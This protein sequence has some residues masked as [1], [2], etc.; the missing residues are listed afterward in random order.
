[1]IFILKSTDCDETQVFT[2]CASLCEP[3]CKNF[4]GNMCIPLRD[5]CVVNVCKCREGHARIKGNDLC[6]PITS[7]ECGGLYD[8][9]KGLQAGIEEEVIF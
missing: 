8:P 7:K 9:V 6:I 4:R 3:Q 1:M 5:K 2:A